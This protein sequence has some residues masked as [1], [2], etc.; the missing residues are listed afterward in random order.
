[1][2]GSADEGEGIGPANGQG[3][4]RALEVVNARALFTRV[5]TTIGG[6]GGVVKSR[7][8]VGNR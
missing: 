4:G 5:V 6:K 2:N 1:M 3:V 8:A 7:Q